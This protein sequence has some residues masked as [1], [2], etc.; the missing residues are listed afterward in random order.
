[1]SKEENNLNSLLKAEEEANR[2][3]KKAEDIRDS[4]RQAAQDQAKSEIS[5]LR[6]QM[7]KDYLAK[8]A[9]EFKDDSV[10]KQKT[11]ETIELHR[12]EYQ[13]HKA[14]V[15]KMLVERIMHV[16]YEVPRNVK[17]DYSVLR[18]PGHTH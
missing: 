12:H 4:M 5:Q 15:I 13:E 14:E 3:I 6:A 9:A 7:E 18:P 8:Q 11:D 16:K 10:L 1:M 2:I 17:A